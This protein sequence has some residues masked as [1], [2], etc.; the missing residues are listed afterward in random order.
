MFSIWPELFAFELL[1]VFLLRIVAGYFFMLMGMRLLRAVQAT[2][3][4]RTALR[5]LCAIY[6]TA[7]LIVGALL[8]VGYYTQ[9]AAAVGVMLTLFP[10]GSGG[11]TSRCEQHVELLLFTITLALLFLGPGAF[12]FDLPI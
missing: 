7:Q 2:G 3:T 11:K 9:P 12:A 4:Q 10:I 1:A 8:F 6:A 5:T